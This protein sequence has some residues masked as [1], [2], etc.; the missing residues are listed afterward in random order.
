MVKQYETSE[1][2]NK[3]NKI[4]NFSLTYFFKDSNRRKRQPRDPTREEGGP[5]PV[6]VLGQK[7][8]SDSGLATRSAQNSW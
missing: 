4:I 7:L 8:G 1:T 6:P 5:R 3:I 2:G